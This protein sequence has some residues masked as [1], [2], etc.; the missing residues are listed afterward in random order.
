MLTFKFDLML[1]LN[2]IFPEFYP[3]AV[4]QQSAA[5]TW[6]TFIL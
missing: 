6:N 4:F 5:Y 1:L 2:D 3:K